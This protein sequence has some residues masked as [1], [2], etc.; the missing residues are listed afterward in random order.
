[1]KSK[2]MRKMIN[3]YVPMMLALSEMDNDNSDI[4]RI[5]IR[6]AL[7]LDQIVSDTEKTAKK[8]F[9]KLYHELF[10]Y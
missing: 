8:K 5:E 6:A 2:E 10:T 3:K 9:D 7:I 4:N 1:M